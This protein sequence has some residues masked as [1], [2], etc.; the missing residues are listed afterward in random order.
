MEANKMYEDV[1]YL[2]FNVFKNEKSRTM[3]KVDPEFEAKILEL[4]NDVLLLEKDFNAKLDGNVW[5]AEFGKAL[6]NILQVKAKFEKVDNKKSWRSL[7]W[8]Q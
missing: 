3:L 7:R 4:I 6:V 2:I 1:V 5:F 8:L